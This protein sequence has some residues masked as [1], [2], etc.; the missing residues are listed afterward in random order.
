MTPIIKS[1]I[2]AHFTGPLKVDKVRLAVGE[3][4][5]FKVKLEGE[6]ITSDV[7]IELWKQLKERK[8]KRQRRTR[9]G[10]E[11]GERSKTRESV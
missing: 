5:K 11:I 7:F 8:R 9:K 2:I 6:A 10:R 3:R 4:N 1:G